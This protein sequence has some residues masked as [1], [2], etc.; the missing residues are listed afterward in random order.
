MSNSVRPHRRQPTRLLCPWDSPGKNMKWVAISFSNEWKWKVEVKSFSCA[1]LL[2]TPWTAAYQ[3]PPSMGFSRQECCLG[4]KLRLP[5]IVT[6]CAFFIP[7]L[8]FW[9]TFWFQTCSWDYKSFLI[10]STAD[11]SRKCLGVNLKTCRFSPH[12]L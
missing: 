10:F 7:S 6:I 1:R 9:T 8:Q 2:A 11:S 3:A 5:K 12:N 4:Q